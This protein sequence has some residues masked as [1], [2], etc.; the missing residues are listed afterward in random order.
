MW[1]TIPVRK[2]GLGLQ[3]IDDVRICRESR[4]AGKHL[5]SLKQ[6]YAKAPYFPD[7]LHFVE[8]LFSTAFD[9]LIDLNMAIIRH[10]ML[11]FGLNTRIVNLSDLNIKSGGDNLIIDICRYFDAST[12]VAQSAAQKYLF[13]DVFERAGVELK[14]FRPP[15][16]IYPQLWGDF[17]PDLSA[18]DLLFNCGPKAWDIIICKNTDNIIGGRQVKSIKKL[19]YVKSSP[20]TDS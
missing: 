3:R 19:D 16:R 14:F 5:D 17:I 13:A 6:A 2:K 1:M 10:L 7:H 8:R 15:T 18:F 12:Y 9:K 20:S 11:N 4:R